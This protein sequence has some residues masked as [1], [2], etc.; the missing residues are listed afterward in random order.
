M[1]VCVLCVDI[2]ASVSSDDKIRSDIRKKGLRNSLR[3]GSL[4]FADD[5]KLTNLDFG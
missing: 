5:H 4:S 1:C 2:T 3:S